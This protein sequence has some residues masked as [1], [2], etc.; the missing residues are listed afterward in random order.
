M[1]EVTVNQHSKFKIQPDGT[2]ATAPEATASPDITALG[3]GRFHV[4]YQHRSYQVEVVQ[5]SAADKTFQIRVNGRLYETQVQ[6]E[7]DQ[8]L[9][10]MGLQKGA[11]AQLSEIKAPMPG[12]ILTISVEV[13]Q[14]VKK[15]DPLLILEAMKMENVL[16]SP[17]EGTISALAVVQ[18]QTVEKNEVLIRFA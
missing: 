3:E 10:S 8:L 17:G 13:G 18:G 2:D 1:Y 11:S 5:R 4:L 7:L 9:A 14:A 6:D 12:L 16:K 15:G